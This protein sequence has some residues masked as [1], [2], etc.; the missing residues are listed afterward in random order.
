MRDRV[1][2]LKVGQVCVDSGMVAIGDPGYLHGA[3]ARNKEGERSLLPGGAG[4]GLPVGIRDVGAVSVWS[5]LGDGSY[6]VHVRFSTR[7]QRV[8][9]VRIV[10][11][12]EGKDRCQAVGCEGGWVRERDPRGV[13]I[14]LGVECATCHGTGIS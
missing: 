8:A 5:G 13:L 9:E 3:L 12:E 11:I 4:Y 6:D 14:S 7:T 10:F 1:N 2:W